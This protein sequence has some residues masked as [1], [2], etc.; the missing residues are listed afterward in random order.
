MQC[1]FSPFCETKTCTSKFF[2]YFQSLHRILARPRN[3]NS[4]LPYQMSVLSCCCRQH[5]SQETNSKVQQS[6]IWSTLQVSS[7]Y[8]CTFWKP[9]HILYIK[10]LYTVID[11]NLYVFVCIVLVLCVLYK[12]CFYFQGHK[13]LLFVILC[14]LFIACTVH[15]C[16]FILTPASATADNIGYI[17]YGQHYC[18]EFLASCSIQSILWMVD[19]W[20]FSSA[21]L[22]AEGTHVLFCIHSVIQSAYHAFCTVCTVQCERSCVSSM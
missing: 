11:I 21:K 16:V 4:T 10:F 1:S 12:G 5:V 8:K 7:V 22:S 15:T 18:V 20:H 3:Y 17:I 2:L 6:E 19:F 13:I 9:M 14:C